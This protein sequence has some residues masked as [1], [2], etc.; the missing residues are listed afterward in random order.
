[1]LSRAASETLPLAAVGTLIK[2]LLQDTY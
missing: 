2:R 1:L